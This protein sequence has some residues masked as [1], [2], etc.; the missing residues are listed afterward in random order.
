MLYLCSSN[1]AYAQR[2]SE[3]AVAEALDAFGSSVGREVIGL[4][5]SSSARGFSPT[6]AG[7]LRIDGFYFDQGANPAPP[8]TR[9]MRGSTVHVGIAA[10]GYLFPAP[11]GVVDYHLRVPGNEA[12]AS[13][14]VGDA[15]YGASY[16]ENDLQLPIVSNVLSIGVGIGFARNPDY[17]FAAQASEWTAGWIVR[18]Q[19]TDK[20]EVTPF[21]GTTD[22]KEYSER[23]TVFIDDDGLPNYRPINKKAQQPWSRMSYLASNAGAIARLSLSDSWVL[24]AALFRAVTYSPIS[25]AALLENIRSNNQG[26]Y[27]ITALPATSSGSTSGEI[28]LA[29]HLATTHTR[30]V[31]TLR[32][33]GRDSNIESA[34]GDTIDY[35]TAPV[36]AVPQVV[37]MPSFVPGPITDVR[38]RQFMPGVAYQGVWQNVGQFTAGLQKV[39]YRRNVDA[40]GLPPA[41]DSNSPWLYNAGASAFLTHSLAA[42]ASYTRGFEEIGTAPINAANRNEPVPAQLTR[43]IDAGLR[44]QLL[45]KLQLVAGVF[46]IDKPYFNLDQFNLFRHVGRISNRGVEF[47][48]TGDV[49]ERLYLVSGVVLLQPRVEYESGAVSGPTTAVAIG[50][51]PGYLNIYAQYRPAAFDNVTIGAVIQTTSSRYLHYPDLNVGVSTLLGADIHYRTHLFNHNATFWLQAYNLANTQIFTAEA[52]EQLHA[53]DPR[54][55]E[56]SLIIDF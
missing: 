32:V 55:Y 39:L 4:Y 43:Q 8:V 38:A 53:I 6:Q 5:S 42:Y 33:T 10:Q 21:F 27:S 45:P 26:D 44:Y 7:N 13:V 1:F 28:R 3:D 40:P 14:L 18:W 52:S 35:G 54:R 31:F 12:V 46:D 25:Y 41:A 24:A 29:E 36:T 48:L 19:P 15:D 23:P 22:H 56:L 37:P 9:I 17:Y 2:S 20:L 30:S 49:T 51:F 50:P 11:T 16:S 34:A 47:S